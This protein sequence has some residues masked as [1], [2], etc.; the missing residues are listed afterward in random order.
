VIPTTI[1]E[2]QKIVA[3]HFGVRASDLRGKSRR[4][5]VCDPRHVAMYLTRKHL[6]LSYPKIAEAFGNRDHSSVIHA[7]RSVVDRTT[8]EM[9]LRE[10][11][12]RIEIEVAI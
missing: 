8:I 7:V 2:I 5:R 10:L 9:R 1:E 6:R 12:Q 4:Q 3:R 11:V